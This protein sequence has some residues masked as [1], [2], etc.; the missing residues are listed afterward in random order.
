MAR[1][2]QRFSLSKR[3]NIS[4]CLGA[5]TMSVL[6]SIST[7]SCGD[8]YISYTE[9]SFESQ[10]KLFDFKLYEK[11]ILRT[12]ESTNT[13]E[14]LGREY[15]SF[16][17][18]SEFKDRF[19]EVFYNFVKLINNFTYAANQEIPG[20][21]N[22]YISYLIYTINL[23]DWFYSKE[24]DNSKVVKEYNPKLTYTALTP[25]S[26]IYFSGLKYM[27]QL[28][29]EEIKNDLPN[30]KNSSFKNLRLFSQNMYMII[31]LSLNRL[32]SAK[33]LQDSVQ[34]SILAAKNTMKFMTSIQ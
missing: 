6:F 15:N 18:D 3:A 25:G 30:L 34:K 23:Y 7:I 17:A 4:S 14:T 31:Q 2:L 22:E 26:I 24:I 32:W 19:K 28:W 10:F 12:L 29:D 16:N 11:K 1:K 5:I 13:I 27:K 9:G 20:I 33:N 8:Y 21:E